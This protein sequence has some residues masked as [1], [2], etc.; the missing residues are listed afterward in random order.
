MVLRQPL[1]LN[2]KQTHLWASSEELFM[3]LFLSLF[4]FISSYAV[5]FDV[6]LSPDQILPI[7][8]ID[9]PLI[10][11]VSGP[12]NT[13]FEMEVNITNI[14]GESVIQFIPD[15][16]IT[17]PSGKYWVSVSELTPLRTFLIANISIKYKN[18]SNEWKIPFCRV[19]RN[20]ETSG[21]PPVVLHNPDNDGLYVAQMI[22]IRKVSFDDNTSD[23]ETR[24]K[25]AI[26]MK[27]YVSFVF[28]YDKHASP[29][30]A[31]EDL[32]NRFGGY[33]STWEIEGNYT[34]DFLNKCVQ[35]ARKSKSIGTF[36]PSFKSLESIPSVIQAVSSEEL[37]EIA[38]SGE[39]QGRENF[40]IVR[41]TIIG[42]G[43]EGIKLFL[44]FNNGNLPADT[45]AQIQKLWEMKSCG[46]DSFVIPY[47]VLIQ[48]G[49]VSQLLSFLSGISRFWGE[50]AESVG[51][52]TYSDNL[53]AFIFQ[54]LTHWFMAFWG[55]EPLKLTG[56]GLATTQLF[57]CYGNPA[58]L[59]QIENGTLSLNSR[60]EPQYLIG[61]TYEVLYK[62]AENALARLAQEINSDTYTSL[63]NPVITNAVKSI[64]DNPKD[65]QSRSHILNLLREL[66]QLEQVQV[67]DYETFV[68]KNLLIAKLSCF[69]KRTCI[70]EQ[71]RGEP[72]REPLLDIITRSEEKITEYLTGSTSHSEN[73]YRAN[74]IL[75]EVHQL[76]E[77]ASKLT[78][79][80]KRIEA[81]GLAYLAESRAQ[82]LEYLRSSPVAI[83]DIDKLTPIT[84]IT[85]AKKEEQKVEP[86]KPTETAVSSESKTSVA[87]TTEPKPK[88]ETTEGPILHTVKR[89][90]TIASISKLYGISEAEFCAWNGVRKGSALKAGKIYKILQPKTKPEQKTE[91]PKMV[92]ANE[93]IV[94]KGDYPALIAKKLGVSTNE[95]LKVNNLTEK[96]R[97]QIGQKLRIPG[98]KK[99]KVE[100]KKQEPASP[101][102]EKVEQPTP[103]EA[104]TQ[105]AVMQKEGEEKTEERR[106]EKLL[107]QTEQSSIETKSEEGMKIYKLLPGDTPAIVAKKFGVPVQSL[108]EFNNITDPTKLR[109]GQELKIPSVE[110][111]KIKEEP[112]KESL[113]SER[114]EQKT[115]SSAPQSTE[116]KI[117]IV[118]KGDNPYTI[119]KKYGVPLDALL[120]ANQLT[121]KSTLSIGQKLIIPAP[122]K[123]Q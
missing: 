18:E 3:T 45:V 33:I 63:K 23:L 87:T 83:P 51:W 105:E 34:P 38:W 67:K 70:T 2:E 44:H 97:L 120:K 59:P 110:G 22:G 62:A 26:S 78:S 55:S 11:A 49:K 57:D 74:W 21:L 10:V 27:Y 112:K 66:P 19:E 117:H 65:S 103:Q 82:S 114:E 119:S 12:P 52:Y 107:V 30:D 88:K 102:Q 75:S 100:E 115:E 111:S 116:E 73:D 60:L 46:V 109:A 15:K 54:T 81:T 47:T 104:V 4:V 32:N 24:I 48:D 20:T 8:F 16:P 121:E 28:N 113:K 7:V 14:N 56:E 98:D 53:H 76:M 40:D 61:N 50:E 37:H 6:Q 25:K 122:T 72:F 96:S 92:D 79:A 90:E 86:P 108:M 29:L 94:Q 91:E 77:R 35:I 95:L 99:Q 93:Y 5:P 9:E 118:S 31:F 85:I 58:T 41:N 42:Y 64:A 123:E 84:P 71:F 43:G 1:V 106:E 17:Y 68:R 36:R 13:P 39:V 80:G 101:S 89:G 69:I